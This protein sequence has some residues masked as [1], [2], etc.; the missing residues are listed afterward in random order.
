MNNLGWDRKY[1]C[2][3]KIVIVKQA[4]IVVQ[5]VKPPLRMVTSHT[6]MPVPVL[7]AMFS[8]LASC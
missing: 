1:E 7:A 6:G 5:Y 3:L 8:H 4:G 2:C